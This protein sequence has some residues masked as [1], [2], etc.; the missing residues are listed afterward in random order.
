MKKQR[1]YR[2]RKEFW[3]VLQQFCTSK[4]QCKVSVLQYKG[5]SIYEHLTI[6]YFWGKD[7]ILEYIVPIILPLD[8]VIKNGVVKNYYES[9]GFGAC[10]FTDI[11]DAK[12]FIDNEMKELINQ[13]TKK[14]LVKYFIQ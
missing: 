7:I 5:V 11:V 9:E 8:T 13:Q 10:Y 14:T 6:P 12:N 3:K 1:T 4:N 2:L